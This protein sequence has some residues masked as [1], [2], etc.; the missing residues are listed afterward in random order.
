MNSRSFILETGNLSPIAW[1]LLTA[2]QEPRL[3]RL[4]GR[5]PHERARPSNRVAS[6]MPASVHFLS[7]TPLLPCQIPATNCETLAGFSP[8]T[9]KP[10]FLRRNGVGRVQRQFGLMSASLTIF[11]HT[12]S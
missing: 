3:L 6:G 1:R 5:Q 9:A 8:Q 11:S 4:P 12:P 2:S 10:E 7:P